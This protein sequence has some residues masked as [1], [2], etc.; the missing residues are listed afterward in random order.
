VS[1]T[2]T[3]FGIEA[4]NTYPQ[5]AA[6]GKHIEVTRRGRVIAELGLPAADP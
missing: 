5:Q 6:D 2:C 3:R 1:F 4:T